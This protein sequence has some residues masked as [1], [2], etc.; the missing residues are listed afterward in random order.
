[1]GAS[2]DSIHFTIS[3]ADYRVS[4]DLQVDHRRKP[5]PTSRRSQSIGGYNR[6]AP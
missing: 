6:S 1:M 2:G 5:C 4:R 3:P